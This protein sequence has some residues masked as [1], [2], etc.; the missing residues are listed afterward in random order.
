MQFKS[1]QSRLTTIFIGISLLTML[2]L[3]AVSI[4]D[5]IT[6]EDFP[7]WLDSQEIELS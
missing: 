1:M 6:I 2:I 3:G 5:C 4:D 7:Q